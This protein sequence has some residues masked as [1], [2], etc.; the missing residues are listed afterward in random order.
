[1][2][3]YCLNNPVVGIDVSGEFREN[4]IDNQPEYAFLS[5]DGGGGGGNCGSVGAASVAAAS[6]TLG[7]G[8]FLTQAADATATFFANAFSQIQQISKDIQEQLI[9]QSQQQV[10]YQYWVAWR[11]DGVVV[12]GHGISLV[13]ASIRV[14]CGWDVLCANE[15]AARWIIV[16]NGYWNYVG[17]EIHGGDGYYWHYHPNRNSHTHIWFR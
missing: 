4:S 17:P 14:A 6:V 15:A 11:Q 16:L 10:Q 12:I 1:M 9:E 7:I 13:D 8:Y 2:F 3:A 5:H